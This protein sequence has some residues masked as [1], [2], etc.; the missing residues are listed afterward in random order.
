MPRTSD[1]ETT[2]LMQQFCREMTS[3]APVSFSNWIISSSDSYKENLKL[4]V[5]ELSSAHKTGIINSVEFENLITNVCGVF[6]ENEIQ[7]RI[8]KVL[9]GRLTTSDVF[10]TK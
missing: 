1:L 7:T 2:S 8:R 4:L 5:R 9:V 3:N 6:I 10:S